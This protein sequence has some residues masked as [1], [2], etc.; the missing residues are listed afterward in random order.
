[1]H[2]SWKTAL[3]LVGKVV[4]GL[5]L[6]LAPAVPALGTQEDAKLVKI[7][8]LVKRGPERCLEKWGPT[9]EAEELDRRIRD[10]RSR[11]V[12]GT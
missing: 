5:I 2:G 4:L 7:G 9:A 6:L 1:M 10:I 8:V 3:H 12:P 11:T